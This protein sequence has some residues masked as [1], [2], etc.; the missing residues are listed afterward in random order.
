MS[1][2]AFEAEVARV[3]DLLCAT[4]LLVW[5]SRTMMPPAAAAARGRQLGTLV[6]VARA[7]ARLARIPAQMVKEAAERRTEG[8]AVW[9]KARADNDFSAFAPV[10]E[11][12]V[13]LE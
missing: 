8:Q 13:S 12:T 5:D 4:N 3:N 11:R 9:T 10:L 7:I 1:Y 6:D 2:A